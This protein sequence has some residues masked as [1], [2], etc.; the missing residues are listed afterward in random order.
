[1]HD[2]SKRMTSYGDM[3]D[4]AQ[5]RSYGGFALRVA[6]G[7]A[8]LALLLWRYDSRTIF[9]VLARERMEF[10]AATVGIYVVGLAVSAF[11]W[12]VLAALNGLGGRYREYLAYYFLG[13]FTNVFVPGL[14]GGDAARALCLGRRRKQLDTAVASVV[15]DRGVGLLALFWFAAACALLLGGL[16][17][18]RATVCVIAA[19]G[20]GSFIGYLAAPLLASAIGR[21]PARLERLLEPMTP[22]LLRPQALIP[23]IVLSVILQTSLAVCQYLL[24]VGLGL[25]ISLST[26]MLV[27]PIANVFTSMPLTFNGLGVREATYLVL[28]GLAGVNRQDAIALGLLWFAATLLGNLSGIIAFVSIGS[29]VSKLGGISDSRMTAD[30]AEE[31]VRSVL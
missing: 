25:R 4:V 30:N 15:A 21:L 29:D 26:M 1:M 13:M 17:L 11:R 10:F 3:G 8:V 22:Y 20:F 27:V 7:G 31:L 28:L 9:Q 19:I 14:V 18:P 2:V 23:A 24:G 12:Q 6:L 5:H 16:P